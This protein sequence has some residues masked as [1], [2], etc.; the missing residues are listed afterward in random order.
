M[1]K[2]IS[3][4]S[5]GS[6]WKR[7]GTGPT[8]SASRPRRGGRR[9][10]HGGCRE[11]GAPPGARGDS[12]AGRHGRADAAGGDSDRPTSTRVPETLPPPPPLARASPPS[13]VT[14]C[15]AAAAHAPRTLGL[16]SVRQSQASAGEMP[17]AAPPTPP[18]L[19]PALSGSFQRRSSRSAQG[20]PRQRDLA[21]G[22]PPFADCA[23]APPSLA[24]HPHPHPHPPSR[25][26]PER[27]PSSLLHLFW[28]HRKRSRQR[29][30]ERGWGAG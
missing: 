2:L 26:A 21:L 4:A 19:S 6:G 11:R 16:E 18:C 10:A 3:G 8:E 27:V 23:P 22:A 17:L 30:R 20:D 12:L 13:H 7:A 25:A 14:T 29:E 9:S 1:E 28:S 24:P 5:T 15:A